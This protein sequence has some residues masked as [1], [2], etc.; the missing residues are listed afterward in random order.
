[1]SL[2]NYKVDARNFERKTLLS[3]LIVTIFKK[4]IPDGNYKVFYFGSRVNGKADIRSDFD[5]GIEAKTPVP[6]DIMFRIQDDLNELDMFQKMDV[7]DFYNVSHEF[8]EFAMKHTEMIYE[9]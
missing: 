2:T 8:K 3:P 9:Q 5:I 6:L 1:M 7:V 4:Y